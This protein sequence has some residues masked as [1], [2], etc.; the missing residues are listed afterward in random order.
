[1]T[2]TRVVWD[3]SALLALGGGNRAASSL[4]VSADLDPGLHLF[5]PA[6]ALLEADQERPGLAE[7]VGALDQLRTLDLD[8]TA[9]LAVSG[10]ART[11]LSL[12]TAHALHACR[13]SPEWPDGILLSTARPK[14]YQGLPIRLLPLPG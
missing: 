3:A 6:L 10:L 5:V 13:P 4:L 14:L 9:T 8:F 1:V 2:D 12:G 7:H 11:G